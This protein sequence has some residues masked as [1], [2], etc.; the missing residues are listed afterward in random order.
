[1]VW[2]VSCIQAWRTSRQPLPYHPLLGISDLSPNGIKLKHQG[3]S[4]ARGVSTVIAVA[5]D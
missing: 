4:Q 5:A 1:M 2:A 3:Q